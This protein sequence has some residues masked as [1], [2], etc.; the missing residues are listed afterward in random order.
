MAIVEFLEGSPKG[1]CQFGSLVCRGNRI[2]TYGVLL[3]HV[4][5]GGIETPSGNTVREISIDL[6]AKFY[7]ATSSAHRNFVIAAAGCCDNCAVE[8][9]WHNDGLPDSFQ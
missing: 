6:N 8:L 3:A 7:S 1:Y 5:R 2:Y 4:S 9:I